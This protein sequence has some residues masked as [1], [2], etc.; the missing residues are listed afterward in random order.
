M[1]IR[2]DAVTRKAFGDSYYEAQDADDSWKPGDNPLE[3][4]GDLERYNDNDAD[5][6]G[7]HDADEQG[8]ANGTPNGSTLA[9]GHNGVKT[10][11]PVETGGRDEEREFPGDEG[12]AGDDEEGWEEDEEGWEEGDEEEVEG[13]GVGA[14]KER[15]LDELYKLDYED[16]IGDIPCRFVC[17]V[18]HVYHKISA[19]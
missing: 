5:D 3:G 19:T 14:E 4:L 8:H 1:F 11:V 16:I 2:W 10:A 13:V 17:S 12:W 7:Y 6:D 9:N 18:T 15:L